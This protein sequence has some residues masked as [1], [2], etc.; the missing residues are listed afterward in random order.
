MFCIVIECF[1]FSWKKRRT[2]SCGSRWRGRERRVWWRCTGWWRRPGPR[3]AKGRW[4][5]RREPKGQTNLTFGIFRV[6]SLDVRPVKKTLFI[7]K[8]YKYFFIEI[9]FCIL[10][11]SIFR[12]N[13]ACRKKNFYRNFLFQND[14]NPIC[15]KVLG[16]QLIIT[17]DADSLFPKFSEFR[18]I[19]E[20]PLGYLVCNFFRKCFFVS[21]K[22]FFYLV[23]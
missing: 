4:R 23:F 8:N 19:F 10:C 5:N 14:T 9:S 2:R 20:A 18:I 7:G 16:V 13:I 21:F 12:T 17:L 1:T 3:S 11:F 15:I 6:A 22:T